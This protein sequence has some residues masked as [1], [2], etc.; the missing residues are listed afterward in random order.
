MWLSWRD[1]TRGQPDNFSR[2]GMTLR[3]ICMGSRWFSCRRH[4]QTQGCWYNPPLTALRSGISP[5]RI[6]A[7]CVGPSY[8]VCYGIKIILL[9]INVFLALRHF[10]SSGRG[11]FLVFSAP[12]YAGACPDTACKFGP[13]PTSAARTVGVRKWQVLSGRDSDHLEPSTFMQTQNHLNKMFD[14]MCMS[15]RILLAPRTGCLPHY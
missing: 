14:G 10:C 1:V 2:L 5:K 8:R 6:F 4:H 11:S 15:F 3:S 7:S 9:C 13:W 12:W